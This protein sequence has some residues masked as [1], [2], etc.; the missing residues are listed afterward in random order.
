MNALRATWQVAVWEFRRLF[1]DLSGPARR[2]LSKIDAVRQAAD[3]AGCVVLLKG[4]DTVIAAPGGGVWPASK[5]RSWPTSVLVP[6]IRELRT[7]SRRR[8]GPM[9]RCGLGMSR[10]TPPRRCTAPV[11][12][13]SNLTTSWESWTRRGRTLGWNAQYPVGSLRTSPRSSDVKA[14]GRM[15]GPGVKGALQSPESN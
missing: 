10:P 5:R 15:S 14:S 9:R 13:S 3:R 12:S 11:A 4:P 6:S 7:A 8:W 1:P 2:D